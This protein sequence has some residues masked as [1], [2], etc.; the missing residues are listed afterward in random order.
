[1]SVPGWID[2]ETKYQIN[3]NPNE[4]PIHAQVNT[5]QFT[6]NACTRA[7]LSRLLGKSPDL[8]FWAS[9]PMHA[10]TTINR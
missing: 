9:I 2:V 1:M 7:V 10:I 4:Y 8:K 6:Q 3:T 5:L